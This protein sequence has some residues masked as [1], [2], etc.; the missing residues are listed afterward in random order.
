MPTDSQADQEAVEDQGLVTGN[1]EEEL[2]EPRTIPE[3]PGPEDNLAEVRGETAAS[4]DHAGDGKPE[5]ETT[6][7]DEINDVPEQETRRAQESEDSVQ[8][9]S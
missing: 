5:A 9:A 3:E 1:K 4:E 8:R 7:K 2:Q 6:V